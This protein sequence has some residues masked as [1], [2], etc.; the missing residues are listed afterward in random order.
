MERFSGAIYNRWGQKLYENTDQYV[1]QWDGYNESGKPAPEG[2]YFYIL[3][4]TFKNGETEQFSGAF[5][6]VR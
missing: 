1:F 2:T 5:E 3:E 4:A 6:L